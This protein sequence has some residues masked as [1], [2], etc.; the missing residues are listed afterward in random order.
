M[1][2]EDGRGNT[3]LNV[4]PAEIQRMPCTGGA[5]AGKLEEVRMNERVGSDFVYMLWRC[6]HRTRFRCGCCMFIV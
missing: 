2:T 4:V 5:S 1:P 3:N 6:F